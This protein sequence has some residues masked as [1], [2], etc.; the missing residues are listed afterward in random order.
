MRVVI[1][2]VSSRRG[3][4]TTI[5]RMVDLELGIVLDDGLGGKGGSYNRRLCE[6]GF[7]Y[8]IHRRQSQLLQKT[9]NLETTKRPA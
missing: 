1:G 3:N 8:T 9:P 2:A 4:R 6:T 7:M 5:E